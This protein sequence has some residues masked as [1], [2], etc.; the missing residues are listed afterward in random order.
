MHG[1]PLQTPCPYSLALAVSGCEH[2]LGG[3]QDAPTLEGAEV[4]YSHLPGLGMLITLL[5]SN[6]PG[7]N[8]EHS[9][10]GG[11]APGQVGRVGNAV[12]Q[13]APVVGLQGRGSA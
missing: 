2:P 4:V 10:C 7:L 6:D 13:R 8:G 5:A 9:A 11:G 12:G 1:G 3:H